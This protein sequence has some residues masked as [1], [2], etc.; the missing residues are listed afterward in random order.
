MTTHTHTHAPAHTRTHISG[1]DSRT[2][3]VPGGMQDGIQMCGN[4]LLQDFL[5]HTPQI[6]KEDKNHAH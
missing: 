4:A 2:F 3:D 6:V 5:L 1:G